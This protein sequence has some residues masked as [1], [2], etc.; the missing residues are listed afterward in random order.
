MLGIP[1]I[2]MA[3]RLTGAAP[4]PLVFNPTNGYEYWA[5]RCQ[6]QVIFR[7]GQQMDL[8][9]DKKPLSE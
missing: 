1:A 7:H 3:G 8:N 6:I 5:T 2:Q 9:L 4:L